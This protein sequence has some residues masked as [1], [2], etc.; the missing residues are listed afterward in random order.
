MTE[1]AR[2]TTICELRRAGSSVSDII[3]STGF[4]PSEVRPVTLSKNPASVMVLAAVASEGKVMPPHFIEAG[5]KIN[6]AEYLK[7]LKDV[8]M[9]WIRRNY[10]PFKVMLVQDS[11]PAH[12]AKK[13]QDFLKENLP[14]M[15]PNDVWPSS[16]PDLNACDYWLFVVIEGK[17]NVTPHPSVNSLKASIRRALGN[18]DPEDVKR[19]CSGFRSRISQII[20][21]KGSHL[22]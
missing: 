10:D 22:E 14:L 12:G 19:S 13:V 11:A 20:D 6:T 18:L 17:S 1:F 8:L 9:L 5:L 3:K 7:I 16:S 15:V 4:D 21:A 2:R